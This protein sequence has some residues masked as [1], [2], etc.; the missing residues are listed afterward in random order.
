M[1]LSPLVVWRNEASNNLETSYPRAHALIL[2]TYKQTHPQRAISVVYKE[3]ILER[4][5]LLIFECGMK[6]LLKN[7]SFSIPSSPHFQPYI[8]IARL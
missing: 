2:A 5:A 6:F 1:E 4:E 8:H 7:I 3:K